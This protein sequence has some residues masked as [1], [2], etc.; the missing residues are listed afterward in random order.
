MPQTR[1][2]SRCSGYDQQTRHGSRVRH[3]ALQSNTTAQNSVYQAATPP[4]CI[5]IKKRSIFWQVRQTN[6]KHQQAIYPPPHANKTAIQQSVVRLYNAQRDAQHAAPLKSPVL[7]IVGAMSSSCSPKHLVSFLIAS[8]YL[9]VQE[10]VTPRATVYRNTARGACA[11]VKATINEKG[12]R[13]R[14][15]AR[16]AHMLLKKVTACIQ[17]TWGA[18]F[19]YDGD[20]LPQWMCT[21]TSAGTWGTHRRR[22]T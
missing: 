13:G 11:Q 17:V 7:L 20:V 4:T 5:Y 9:R 8:E 3:P 21:K 19:Q 1:S 22:H 18:G 12:G 15:A 10:K 2:R 16:K 6:T 14:G